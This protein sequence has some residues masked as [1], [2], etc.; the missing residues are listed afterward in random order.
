MGRNAEIEAAFFNVAR[1]HGTRTRAASGGDPYVIDDDCSD[2]EDAS[3]FHDHETRDT[4]SRGK[5]ATVADVAVVCDDAAGVEETVGP[6][7]CFHVENA[8]GIED[9][10]RADAAGG[11]Y[12]GGGMDQG[13][14]GDVSFVQPV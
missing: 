6:D 7:P 5:K 14:E 4:D 11:I 2:A 12:D 3:G 10:A 8:A 13:R 1:H 9:G